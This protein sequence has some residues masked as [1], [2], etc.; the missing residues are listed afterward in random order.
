MSYYDIDE[1]NAFINEQFSKEIVEKL[2]YTSLK[3]DYT[4]SPS[5]KSKIKEI[6]KICKKCNID[7]DTTTNLIT[8]MIDS[9]QIV[10]AGLKSV[11]RGIRFNKIIKEHIIEMFECYNKEIKNNYIIEFETRS[12]NVPT[13]EIPDWTIYDIKNNKT[14]VGMNQLD[15]WSGG[16]Q[17]NRGSKYI[18][19][20][21][22]SGNGI[23]LCVVCNYTKII[24]KKSKKFN[25]FNI[26]FKYGTLCYIT[27]L[28]YN[29][30]KYFGM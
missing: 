3:N 28:E 24:R 26:G 16:H 17:T 27:K 29:I 15:L 25:L 21:Q 12:R 13:D 2:S 4:N 5:L 11:T 14:I 6:T 30:K 7:N 20:K 19:E 1:I 8:M 18:T 22:N 10:S 23:I 9:D